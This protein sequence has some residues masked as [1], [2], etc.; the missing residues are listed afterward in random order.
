MEL[1]ARTDA[2]TE[3][4][5]DYP[6]SDTPDATTTVSWPTQTAPAQCPHCAGELINGQGVL[7]C[8]DCDWTN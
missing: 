4:T 7:D 2:R 8:L 5:T 3:P 6:F 1:L